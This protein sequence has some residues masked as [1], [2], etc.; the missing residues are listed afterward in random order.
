MSYNRPKNLIDSPI[1]K[2]NSKAQVNINLDSFTKNLDDL[3]A[4]YDQNTQKIGLLQ[5]KE[6]F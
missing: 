1:N 2:E 3:L 4:N 5:K 6:D